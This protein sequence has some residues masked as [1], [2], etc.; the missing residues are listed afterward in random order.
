MNQKEKLEK[1]HSLER[2]INGE[3]QDD[4]LLVLDK[5]FSDD[6]WSI[7][8]AV[9]EWFSVVEGYIDKDKVFK[10]N[11][12]DYNWGNVYL[13]ITSVDIITKGINNLHKIITNDNKH[14]FKD[15][16][17]IFKD[18]QYDDNKYFQNI[19]AIFGAHCTDLDANGEFIVATYPTPYD[20]SQDLI[21]DKKNDWDYYTLL[22]SKKKS[23]SL[24]QKPFGF[25]FNNIDK[26]L[27]KYLSYLDVFYSNIELMILK[28]KENLSKKTINKIDNN[29]LEQL[30]LLIIEDEKRLHGKYNYE[31]NCFKKLIEIEISDDKNK[32]LYQNY[33]NKLI[34]VIPDLYN[35][36]QSPNEYKNI[37]FI[38]DLIECDIPYIDHMTQYYYSKVLE[39]KNNEAISDLLINYF[40]NHLEPFNKNIKTI[41]ELFCLIK[42]HNYYISINQKEV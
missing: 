42:A 5:N 32:T 6:K 1:L 25:N 30:N 23:E 12:S 41:K 21:F 7:I 11:T 15:E 14:L 19:R 3:K 4:I 28:Y 27:S 16:K 17:D 38:N 10:A 8:C 34:F 40:R 29:P 2:F 13:Y 33:K 36:I 24:K 39:Y 35:L 22:W 18:D 9:M 31:L 26:Y 37:D 20:S